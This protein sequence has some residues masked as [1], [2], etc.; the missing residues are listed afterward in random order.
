MFSSLRENKISTIFFSFTLALFKEHFFLFSAN[1]PFLKP[2]YNSIFSRT[3]DL[4]TLS[5][6]DSILQFGNEKY[7]EMS[8]SLCYVTMGTST[9][10]TAISKSLNQSFA[11]PKTVHSKEYIYNLN[12][13]NVTLLFE[14]YCVLICYSFRLPPGLLQSTLL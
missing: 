5:I 9:A 12:I 4:Y 8:T 1:F 14:E 6:F 7:E 11:S 10:S 13:Y 2:I 3:F